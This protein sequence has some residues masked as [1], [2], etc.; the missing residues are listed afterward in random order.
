MMVFPGDS[1]NLASLTYIVD[2]D[3]VD[4]RGFLSV[5]RRDIYSLTVTKVLIL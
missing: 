5:D 2:G 4:R 1:I 3:T